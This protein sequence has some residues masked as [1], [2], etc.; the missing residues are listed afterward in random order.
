LVLGTAAGTDP[1]PRQLLVHVFVIHELVLAVVVVVLY[2]HFP[3]VL[4]GDK[5]PLLR[6]HHLW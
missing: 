1:V 2:C 5:L 3:P 6:Q 4:L